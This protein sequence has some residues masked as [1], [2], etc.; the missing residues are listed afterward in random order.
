MEKRD[1]TLFERLREE[2]FRVAMARLEIPLRVSAKR[3][4]QLAGGRQLFQA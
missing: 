1:V 4:R 3:L 2:R